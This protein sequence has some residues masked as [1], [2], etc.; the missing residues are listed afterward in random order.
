MHENRIREILED[1][2][3]GPYLNDEG[4]TDISYNGT[5]LH[6][7][8]NENGRYK[9]PEQPSIEEV[10]VLVKQISDLQKGSFTN[11]EPVLDTEI[12]YLRLNAMHNAISPDGMTFAVRVSRP[13]LS[14]GSVADLITGSED[15]VEKLLQVLV[16][17][18]SNIVI[19]GRT[20]SGKTEFQK[21][22]VGFIPDDSK[23]TLIEDTRDSHIKAIYPNKDINSWKTIPGKFEMTDGV[24]AAL[25]NNPD[26]TII[27]ETRGEVS[28]DVLDSAKTDHAILTTIHA[29]GA[30]NIP[31]RLIPMIRQSSAYAIID[32]RLIGNEIVEFLRF[33]IHLKS[34]QLNGRTVRKIKEI[35]EY[36]DF[37]DKGTVGTYLYREVKIL[38]A[39]S[40]E[41]RVEQQFNPL[42]AKTIGELEDKELI[43][44]LPDVFKPKETSV[45]V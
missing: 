3:I 39:L 43:H 10:K 23:I 7:Q 1:S 34:E 32:D 12:G 19:S 36:T 5:S 27:A 26:W 13:R 6:I 16:L 22:L 38:D 44:L 40:G 31:S 28:A 37:T 2:F 4:I 11:T 17:A 24:R 14:A 20:G 25:R 30:M 8:H 42:T 41:Y 9:A 45:G 33:G 29:K 21:L 35:V 18:E 15:M